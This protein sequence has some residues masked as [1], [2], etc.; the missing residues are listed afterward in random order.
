[1]SNVKRVFERG[2]MAFASMNEDF[3][4]PK[5]ATVLREIEIDNDRYLNPGDEID[6][7]N[8]GTMFFFGVQSAGPEDIVLFRVPGD[9]IIDDKLFC[10]RTEK[11]EIQ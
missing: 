5:K 2:P 4:T 7:V 1:M 10:T 9:E 8:V 6:V 11:L 3:E